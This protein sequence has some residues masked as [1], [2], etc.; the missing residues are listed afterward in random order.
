MTEQKSYVRVNEHGVMRVGETRVMLDSVVA[1]FEKGH[2]AETI[3]EEYP[4]LTLEEVYGAITY[5]LSHIDEVGEYLERQGKYWDQWR[6]KSSMLRNP[7]A[8]RIRAL[9]G[10]DLPDGGA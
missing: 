10:A 4:A 2:S 5:Y 3:R 8:E 7:V 6:A 9:K 1:S